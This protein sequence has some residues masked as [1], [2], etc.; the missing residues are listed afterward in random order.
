MAEDLDQFLEEQ[1]TKLAE[2]KAKLENDPPYMEMQNK[3]TEKLSET[4]EM[5]ISMA[6]ENIP[7]NSQQTDYGLSLPLGEDYEHKKHKLKEELRQDY[8]RYLSQGISQAKKKKKY[9]T[10]GE[11]DPYTQGLSLPIGDR[12]SAKDRLRVERNKEYNQYLREK[13]DCNERLRRDGKRHIEHDTDTYRKSTL[14]SREQSELH[15]PLRRDEESL[16][17]DASTSTET[18]E[19]LSNSKPSLDQHHRSD[20]ETGCGDSVLHEKLDEKLNISNKKHQKL[21]G[22]SCISPRRHRIFDHDPE[23]NDEMDPRFRYESDYDRKPLRVFHA[24]RRQGNFPTKE[25][26]Q[27]AQYATGLIIG[28]Q[29]RELIQRRKEQYRQELME[30]IAEQQRNKRREKELELPVATSGALDPEKM[31]SEEKPNRLKELGLAP[32]ILKERIPPEKPRPAFQTPTPGPT[33]ISAPPMSPVNEDS[34]RG[35]STTLGEMLSPRIVH[36]SAPVPPPVVTDNYKTPYDDAYYYYGARNPLDP[37]LAHDRQP[38]SAPP[39]VDAVHRSPAVSLKV[40]AKLINDRPRRLGIV[41]EEKQKSTKDTTLAYQQEL[42]QQIKEREE[43]RRQ[44]KEERERHDAKLEAEMRSYNPWGKG[45]GGAPLRDKKGN[46]ITDLNMMHKQNEDAYHNPEARVYE[47]KMAIASV[48]PGLASPSLEN[49]DDSTN[50]IAGFTYTQVSPFARG[51]VFGETPTAEQLRRQESY[52]NFLCFQIEE[53]RKR[54]EEER[55]K[56]RLEE[57][58]EERRLADQ[59]ARIQREYEEERERKRKKEEEQRLKNEELYRLAEERRKEAEKKKL[60]EEERQDKQNNE[61]ER[62][63]V[64]EEE[65]ISRQA[66]PLIPSLQ[67]KP[68]VKEERSLLMESRTSYYTHDVP[69]DQSPPVPARRNQLRAYE[70]RKNVINELSEMRKQLRSEERRLQEQLLKVHSDDDDDLSAK[71]RRKDKGYLDVFEM[72]RLRMQAPVR[73]P[74]SKEV[75][76]PI[77]VQNIREFNEL[78]YKDSDTRTETRYM[79]P[80]P[81]TNDDALD[82]QQQALLREQKKKLKKLRR[83]AEAVLDF[84]DLE[85]SY[86]SRRR[87]MVMDDESNEFMKNSLLESESAFIATDGEAFLPLEVHT[88]PPPLS[89]RERRREKKKDDAPFKVTPPPQSDNSSLRSNSSLNIEQL[90][91]R[92]EERLQRLNELQKAASHIADDISLGN[93]DDILKELPSKDVRRSNSVDTVATEPWLRPGTSETLKRFMSEQSSQAKLSSE[94]NVPFNWQGLSTAHG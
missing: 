89:A 9:L 80:D 13:E 29:D 62:H 8:R 16:K 19:G 70:E 93:A 20:N 37:N 72:A 4:S 22:K 49:T 64:I 55:E 45:G 21:D 66:S 86:K 69:R 14:V 38:S 57:E 33:S 53:K 25:Q 56:R 75:A 81:P 7:P 36:L 1:K 11:V 30:Q 47:D 77:N 40:E 28:G 65:K 71:G 92:N 3:S 76:D 5:L 52:K 91:A 23:I 78:K 59:R 46:L 2:D 31:Q 61:T 39:P 82:I 6:K 43:R 10:S 90:K 44:E 88:T 35:L 58:K 51:N 74:S 34:H 15:M 67:N 54:E 26:P 24:Q 63:I 60:E 32:R 12:T 17:K 73:R 50:K 48:D 84:D 68:L 18:Y 94:K 42:Q 83:N 87:G 79:Y 41:P 85:S 27:S